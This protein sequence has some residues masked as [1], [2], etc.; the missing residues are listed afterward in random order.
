MRILQKKLMNIFAQAGLG[1]KLVIQTYFER[2]HLKIL[3]FIPVGGLGLDFV[4]D[5]G[6][7]LKQIEAGDFDSSKS[8]YAG[9]IDG[10]NV[11]AADIEAKNN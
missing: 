7:N 2:V 11:W 3:K 1:E 9:I 8:L 5:N 10:R 4:H 6:Y